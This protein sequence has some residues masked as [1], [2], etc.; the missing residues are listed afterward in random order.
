[1]EKVKADPEGLEE[2]PLAK[3]KHKILNGGQKRTLLGGPKERKASKAC[4]IAMMAF[5]RVFSPLPSR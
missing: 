5:R 3:N 2:H 4:H 1:M